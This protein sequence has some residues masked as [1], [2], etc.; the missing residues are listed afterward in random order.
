MNPDTTNAADVHGAV[1]TQR[2]WPTLISGW[3]VCDLPI[4]TG[5]PFPEIPTDVEA[6]QIEATYHELSVHEPDLTDNR[7]WYLA[8]QI[9][10]RYR[11]DVA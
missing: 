7:A 6:Q 8:G 1:L 10:A 2:E 5:W 9:V 3:G 4:C 11:R